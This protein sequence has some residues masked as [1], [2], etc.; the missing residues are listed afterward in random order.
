MEEYEYGQNRAFRESMFIRPRS[1][2]TF[3]ASPIWRTVVVTFADYDSPKSERV[4]SKLT[5]ELEGIASVSRAV[6]PPLRNGTEPGSASIPD[7][8]TIDFI[9]EKNSREMEENLVRIKKYA[10]YVGQ[11]CWSANEAQKI[12]R[13]HGLTITSGCLLLYRHVTAPITEER[14]PFH[15]LP[16][17]RGMKNPRLIIAAGTRCHWETKNEGKGTGRGGGDEGDI[18]RLKHRPGRSYRPRTGGENNISLPGVGESSFSKEATN[19]EKPFRGR[20]IRNLPTRAEKS[21]E[22]QSENFPPSGREDRPDTRAIR[23]IVQRPRIPQLRVSNTDWHKPQV[24]ARLALGSC[25][26]PTL[27]KAVCGTL[28]GW[29]IERL[30][31]ELEEILKFAGYGVVVRV[32]NRKIHGAIAELP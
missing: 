3:S 6:S 10:N 17:A 14:N 23:N 15:A 30:D 19:P 20:N 5:Q 28:L 13:R 2:A 21:L 18:T 4:T 32:L 25:R 27:N 26:F 9:C 1:L 16:R 24:A 11:E 22:V 7:P 12:Q 29:V 8:L 31:Q